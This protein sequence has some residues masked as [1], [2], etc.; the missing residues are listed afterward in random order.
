MSKIYIAITNNIHFDQR[1]Q[2]ISDSLQMAGHQVIVIYRDFLKNNFIKKPDHQTQYNF[3]TKNL[4]CVFKK[5]AL[6]YT[7]YNIKL[8]LFLMLNKFD[9]IC[10]VDLDTLPAC[11]L[12]GKIK[13]KNI[14]FDAHEYF[15]EVPELENRKM[16]KRI[17]NAIGNIFVPMTN[18]RYT[19]NQSLAEIFTKKYNKNFEI[20]RN[21]PYSMQLKNEIPVDK[22]L[23]YQ[24]AVNKGRGLDELIYAMHQ[25]EIPL[26]I[27]GN[28][29][30]FHEIKSLVRKEKLENKISL[31]GYI[32]PDDLKALTIKAFIGYN[33]LNKNSK[34]YQYS[35]SNKFFDYIQ[36]GIP[37]LSNPFPEYSRIIEQFQVGVLLET[38]R[39]KIAETI[40]NLI[41]DEK[42]YSTLVQNC[43]IA[44]KIFCWEKEK[45]KL[46]DLYA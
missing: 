10:S 6:F 34:S 17:W 4:N 42:K 27:A 20:I 7:E 23:I 9:T 40:N 24:G 19:V 16:I 30:I 26:V 38:Q 36:A 1:I 3:K 12:A 11:T 18:I 43:K 46:V 35:L 13:K 44:K 28:G 31:T 45:Q 15:T 25:I 33:L 37:S 22:Y 39:D 32:Y 29:D 5:S 41:Q 8:F 2:R 21:L 14:A